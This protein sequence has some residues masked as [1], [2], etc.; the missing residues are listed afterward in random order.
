MNISVLAGFCAAGHGFHWGTLLICL[1]MG[2]K[3]YTHFV[4][5]EQPSV[6]SEF[7]GVVELNRVPCRQNDLR[8]IA[9]ILARS[10]DVDSQDIRILYW[11]RLH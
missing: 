1:S 9:A 10:L 11:S 6:A 5:S 4:M 8:D 3:Y 7:T 2:V